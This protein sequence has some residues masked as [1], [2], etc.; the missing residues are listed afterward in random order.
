MTKRSIK[1]LTKRLLILT[2][3]D[4]KKC[5]EVQAHKAVNAVFDQMKTSLKEGDR[6]EIRGMFSMAV[7][8]YEGFAG[9]NPKTGEPISVPPKK[10]PVFKPS[11]EIL[12]RLNGMSGY[13]SPLGRNPK[14][15]GE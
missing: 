13:K 6:I 11:R 7:K 14:K 2:L 9:R 15:G 4:R 10:L 3:A 12:R 1:T 5:S 8:D